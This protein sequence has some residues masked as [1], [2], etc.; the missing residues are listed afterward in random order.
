[1]VA[2]T[3]RPGDAFSIP[4]L[5]IARAWAE[6][7]DLD[8]RVELDR[9]IDGVEPEEA[10][11]FYR[12]GCSFPRWTMWHSDRCVVVMP[13]FGPARSF[14]SLPDALEGVGVGVTPPA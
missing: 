6:Y 12:P 11:A 4:D 7:H 5:M 8:L 10:L 2:W 3:P 14:P 1:M 9:A 13:D